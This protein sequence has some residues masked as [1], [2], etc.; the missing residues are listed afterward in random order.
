MGGLAEDHN[1]DA[2]NINVVQPKRRRDDDDESIRT[3]KDFSKTVSHHSP[4]NY[5][6][7]LTTDHEP[8]RSVSVSGGSKDSNSKKKKTKL[9][10][11][12]YPPALKAVPSRSPV[13]DDNKGS[14]QYLD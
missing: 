3:D 8:Q 4:Q 5:K 9:T 1:L 12:I 14:D 2:V 6:F 13:G 10:I 7:N 11:K